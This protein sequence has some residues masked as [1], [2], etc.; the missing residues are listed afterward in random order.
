[1]D[2]AWYPSERH[3]KVLEAS[4]QWNY[5]TILNIVFP[6]LAAVLLYRFVRSGDMPMLQMMGGSP[7]NDQHG[8]L[9]QHVHHE[10]EPVV[11]D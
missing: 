10:E 3:A 1:M 6:A 7:S 9:G 5:T 8:G 11:S 4:I 2:S